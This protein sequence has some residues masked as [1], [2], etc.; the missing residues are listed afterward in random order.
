[1]EALH[2]RLVHDESVS[3]NGCPRLD[4][5]TDAFSLSLAAHHLKVSLKEHHATPE[6]ARSVVEPF[7]RGWER[8]VALRL[9]RHELEL[10]YVN[11]DIV[12]RNP[13]PPGAVI[14]SP[15]PAEMVLAGASASV[16]V[17]RSEYPAPPTDFVLTPEVEIL[18]RQYENYLDGRESIAAVAYWCFTALKDVAGRQ[19]KRAAVKYG[20]SE[21]VLENVNKLAARGRKFLPGQAALSRPEEAWLDKTIKRLI[22]RVGEVARDREA[23][24]DRITLE[25]L[26]LP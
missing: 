16:H 13:P 3:Y 22:R 20:V 24:D 23:A 26:P 8:D 14:V 4:Y 12:L 7:L 25:Q 21:G 9:R 17:G 6:S 2:Y 1:M 11:A 5:E 15:A 19:G 18:W 10:K